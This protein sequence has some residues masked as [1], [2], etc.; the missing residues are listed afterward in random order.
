MKSLE[1]GAMQH[2][3]LFLG[4]NHEISCY[5]TAIAK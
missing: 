2:V 4:N 1:E 3:D 5:T